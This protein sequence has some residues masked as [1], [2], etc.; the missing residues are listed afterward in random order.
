MELTRI[1]E[2]NLSYFKP[3]LPPDGMTA[4]QG[5]IGIVGDGD[6]PIAAAL[7][8]GKENTVSLD[9]IFVH[10]KFRGQ[11]I[12]RELIYVITEV[13]DGKAENL[14]V[15]YVDAFPGFE[16]FLRKTGF[17]VTEGDEVYTIPVSEILNNPDAE[18][19]LE[20]GKNVNIK[21]VS[22]LS[23]AEGESAGRLILEEMGTY[24]FIYNC[25]P[26]RS[27][28]LL[29]QLG[30]VHSVMLTE[31]AEEGVTFISLLV[32]R[33]TPLQVFCLIEHLLRVLEQAGETGGFLRFVAG[34][35]SV[36]H[37]ADNI[38]KDQGALARTDLKLAYMTLL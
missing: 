2:T 16:E 22:D 29:D 26:E 12:G 34:T 13:F 38:L 32:N 25:D 30:N 3:L 8:S 28:C 27:F 36:E 17:F 15:S 23:D 21:A 6:F 1:E 35:E 18:R 4:E 9:W 14:C 19:Y 24:R 10:P 37:F 20:Q 5:G 11:G 7:L 33:G 31:A